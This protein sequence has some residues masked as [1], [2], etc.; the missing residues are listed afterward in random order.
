MPFNGFWYDYAQYLIESRNDDKSNQFLSVNF[1]M[2]GANGLAAFITF[3]LLD[4]PINAE[5]H[6]F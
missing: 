2:N 1:I 3:A 4:L 6:Q 5:S